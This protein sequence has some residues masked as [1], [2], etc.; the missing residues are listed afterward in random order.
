MSTESTDTSHLDTTNSE[1]SFAETALELGGKSADEA[2]RTGA[3]DRADDQ[4]EKLFAPQ[5]QTVH[6]P[7]HRA[8]WDRPLP[9]DVFM[10]RDS[11]TPAD[12][13]KIMD[14]S[15]AIVEK[16]RNTQML[17]DEHGKIRNVILEELADAGYWGLLVDREYGGSG[18][19]FCRQSTTVSNTAQIW[20]AWGGQPGM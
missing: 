9:V 4:V 14:D 7:A 17:H 19:P 10:S 15:L 13:E 1:K 20:C 18:A 5:Y 6:S 8:V 2:R 3:I 11:E 16:Y 12:V